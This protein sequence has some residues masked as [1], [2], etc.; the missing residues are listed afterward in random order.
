MSQDGSGSSWRPFFVSGVTLSGQVFAAEF[1]IFSTFSPTNFANLVYII[2]H[3]AS[4]EG[5]RLGDTFTWDARPL[6]RLLS[7]RAWD[8]RVGLVNKVLAVARALDPLILDGRTVDG[9]L[10]YY[11]AGSFVLEGDLWPAQFA[12]E[13]IFPT[14]P[15]NRFNLYCAIARRMKGGCFLKL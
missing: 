3:R 2:G 15:E 5:R 9:G 13:T 10:R 6:H 7:A 11:S 8:E 12:V 14:P 4:L 1:G